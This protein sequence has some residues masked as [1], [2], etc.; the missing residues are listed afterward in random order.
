MVINTLLNDANSKT[1]VNEDF[2]RWIEIKGASAADSSKHIK[3]AQW[4]TKDDPVQMKLESLDGS[5]KAKINPY[6]ANQVTGNMRVIDWRPLNK[7][8]KH[9]RHIPFPNIWPRPVVDIMIVIDYTELHCA[10][11]CHSSKTKASTR[12]DQ[13]TLSKSCQ[14][15]WWH[16]QSS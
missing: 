5:T 11:W 2:A 14:G 12:F 16:L 3:W 1:Y 13:C 7:T 15:K 4:N 10:H 9:L 6:T 8:W